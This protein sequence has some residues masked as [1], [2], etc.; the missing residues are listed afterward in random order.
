MSNLIEAPT[1]APLFLPD[2]DQF[3]RVVP[4][5]PVF[6]LRSAFAQVY[7]DMTG[8]ARGYNVEGDVLTQTIDGRPLNE[9]WNDF[10]ALLNQWNQSRS[11]IVEALTF[12]VV[13]PIEDVAQ[14][15]G[16]DFERA[17]EFGVPKSIRG[18]AF[19]QLG[20]DFEWYDLAAR[21]TWK[22]LA[23]AR[24]EQVSAMTNMALEADNRL[25]F[26]QVL[27]AIFNNINRVADIRNQAI[28]VYPFYNN[29]GT[30]PPRWK[31]QTHLGTHDH[32]VSAGGAPITSADLDA[33]EE[34]L[35][36]HGYGRQNGSTL[37]LMV[38]S[39]ELAVIRSFRVATGSSYDFIP[40]GGQPPWLLPTNTGGVVVPQGAGVPTNVGGMSVVGRYGSWLIV[41]EDYIPPGYMLGFATGGGNNA[42][43]PVGFRE[44]ANPSLRGMRIVKGR[45][46]DYPLIDSYYQR[47]FG[48]GIR[49][50]GAGIVMQVAAGAYVIPADYV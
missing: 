33:M 25:T 14:G 12:P 39:Q 26:S 23:E 32:Y 10:L 22:F 34:H 24:A 35:K 18:G 29:D 20:Y 8:Q 28:N 1:R 42:T 36:H 46:P 48:T 13:E 9:M 11:V 41:E 17:S 3:G 15:G 44:H 31:N 37:V 45:E 4:T 21:F 38:N 7:A 49:H 43:N 16:D 40:G 6:D 19:F 2:T 30:V 5:G 47:G 50:R 27:R